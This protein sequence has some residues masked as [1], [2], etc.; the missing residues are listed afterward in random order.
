MKTDL[1]TNPQLPQI[2]KELL[3]KLY[4]KEIT[5]TDFNKEC[6]YWMTGDISTMYYKHDMTEKPKALQEYEEKLQN[7]S[8]YSLPSTF[9]NRADIREYS[10]R[11]AH[12]KNE[13]HANW[14][15]LHFIKKYIPLEDK[16]NH[17]KIARAIESYPNTIKTFKQELRKDWA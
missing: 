14:F 13:N 2:G 8:T 11:S 6:A 16:I 15:W 4:S 7:D 10:L 1:H 12:A 17:V 9:W 3:R 5:L